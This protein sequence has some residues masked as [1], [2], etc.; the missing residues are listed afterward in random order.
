[1][2][3]F[4][5]GGDSLAATTVATSLVQAGCQVTVADLF[6]APTLEAFIVRARGKLTATPVASQDAAPAAASAVVQVPR[7]PRRLPPSR[8]RR[9]PQPPAERH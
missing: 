8:D 6:A 5:L 9:P 7:L 3:F 1:M 4:A 2:N